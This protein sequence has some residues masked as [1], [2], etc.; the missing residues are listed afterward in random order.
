MASSLSC[1]RLPNRDSPLH[2][3]VLVCKLVAVSFACFSL[4][5]PVSG[6]LP[7]QVSSAK[8]LGDTKLLDQTMP[9]NLLLVAVSTSYR[10]HQA[11]LGRHPEPLS[12]RGNF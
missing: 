6:D 12:K 11:S 1:S 4:T 8:E 3:S 10:H 9:I 7:R 5:S 2:D